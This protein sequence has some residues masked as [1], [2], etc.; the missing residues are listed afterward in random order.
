MPTLYKIDTIANNRVS[1]RDIAIDENDSHQDQLLVYR[2]L[3]FSTVT[4][5]NDYQYTSDLVTSKPSVAELRTIYALP[6]ASASGSTMYTVDE[7]THEIVFSTTATD[8]SWKGGGVHHSRLNDTGEAYDIQLPVAAAGETVRIL[9]KTAISPLFNTFAASDSI[10]SAKIEGCARQV[11]NVLEEM[12]LEKKNPVL[13]L[14]RGEP[15][16]IC[17]LDSTATIPTENL[18]TNAMTGLRATAT[19]TFSGPTSVTDPVSTITIISSPTNEHPTGKPVTYIAWESNGPTANQFRVNGTLDVLTETLTACINHEKGHQG[20]IRAENKGS[21]VVELTQLVGGSG[22][23]TTIVE[24][25]ATCEITKNFTQSRPAFDNTLLIQELQDVSLG[26][27]SYGADVDGWMLEFANGT[28][29]LEHPLN[30]ITDV[31]YVETSPGAMTLR[32]ENGDTLIARTTSFWMLRDI[33]HLNSANAQA[34]KGQIFQYNSPESEWQLSKD[35]GTEMPS[36]ASLQWDAADSVWYGGN[37]I[38]EYI[39]R[40]SGFLYGG[41]ETPAPGFGSDEGWDPDNNPFGLPHSPTGADFPAFPAVG[42]EHTL[43]SEF[44]DVVLADVKGRQVLR[45][46]S[47]T[48]GQDACT[49]EAANWTDSFGTEHARGVWRN[50]SPSLRDFSR[51]EATYGDGSNPHGGPVKVSYYTSESMTSGDMLQWEESTRTWTVRNLKEVFE[52]TFTNITSGNWTTEGTAIIGGTTTGEPENRTVKL[53]D[54]NFVKMTDSTGQPPKDGTF[55][56]YKS[57]AEPGDGQGSNSNLNYFHPFEFEPVS[58]ETT[59][60]P[61]AGV[62]QI[63]VTH[64]RDYSQA[65]LDDYIDESNLSAQYLKEEV[66]D[67]VLVERD[68]KLDFIQLTPQHDRN[69]A[70][71]GRYW[72]PNSGSNWWSFD[73]SPHWLQANLQNYKASEEQHKEGWKVYRIA[74]SDITYDEDGHISNSPTPVLIS[75]A[76]PGRWED[77]ATNESDADNLISFDDIYFGWQSDDGN[78]NGGVLKVHEPCSAVPL[79]DLATDYHG[80]FP[81]KWQYSA[82]G[83]RTGAGVYTPITQL[84]KGDMLI[85]TYQEVLHNPNMTFGGSIWAP[86]DYI[87]AQAWRD[88]TITIGGSEA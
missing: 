58:N 47:S 11:S 37:L 38:S 69:G 30:P 32:Y 22:G 29:A 77:V 40:I 28:W 83:T 52:H 5:L 49:V 48:A 70:T 26:G 59:T 57:N 72:G 16:G 86:T 75:N 3:D 45:W 46:D 53:D 27:L 14:E 44:G 36:N 73:G 55:L 2:L 85:F 10:K 66:V 34:H 39:P 15:L 63:T 84:T 4:A 64:T 56:I 51:S 54:L 23:V 60:P 82:I 9:R 35:Q 62:T 65:E 42:S 17:P 74:A 61:S 43:V 24:T 8:Y 1:Y 68:M 81:N 18:N 78:N 88:Q 19:L 13:N 6:N 67:T 25:V 33:H 50:Y 31:P 80:E 7:S 71:S 20:L 41:S 87:R 21:G 79:A 12:L 76:R